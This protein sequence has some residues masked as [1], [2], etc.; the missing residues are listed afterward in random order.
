MPNERT[1]PSGI[2]P[3]TP[4]ARPTGYQ[5]MIMQATGCA[6]AD[7]AMVEDIM[8]NEVFHST[9]DWQTRSE[10]RSVA[11]KA[12]RI[13][14]ENRALYA[15]FYHAARAARLQMKRANVATQRSY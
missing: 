6:A 4:P 11:R 2:E 3:E 8:R 14:T 1:E 5:P 13:L 9:L 12:D 10:F 7:A 15:G